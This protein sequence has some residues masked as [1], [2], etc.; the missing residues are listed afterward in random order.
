MKKRILR[1]IGAGL[2]ALVCLGVAAYAVVYV[3]SERVLRAKHPVPAV[4]ISIPTDAASIEE[5]RRLAVI[6]GCF[7]GCHGKGVE[8]SVMFDEPM[9]ARIMAPNLTQT[10]RRYSDAQFAAAVRNGV[11]PDGRSMLIMPSEAFVVLSDAD[12]GRIMAYLKS[13]PPVEGPGAAV[14]V[15][16]LGRIGLAAGKFKTVAQMIAE[17]TPLPAATSAEGRFGRYRAQTACASCHGPDLRGTS[18]PEFTSPDLRVVAAYTPEA[19]SDLL[20]AGSALGGRD[21][22]VMGGWARE[23]LSLLSSEEIAALYSYLRS[24]ATA[25]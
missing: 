2:A 12:L 17:T 25:Q 9:V 14:S 22:P 20:R 19:F 10:I 11:R 16:P 8:G 4:A 21:L 18:N 6:H 15:G 3:M 24:Q 23:H 7:H 5:G 13:L 1:W